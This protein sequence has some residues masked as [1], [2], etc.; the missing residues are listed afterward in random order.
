[1]SS[2]A[3]PAGIRAML[4]QMAELLLRY[5]DP[6]QRLAA[7][8]VLAAP[9][10]FLA[11]AP[12]LPTVAEWLRFIGEDTSAEALRESYQRQGWLNRPESGCKSPS[13]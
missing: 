1:M 11:E 7:A 2:Y 3:P 8:S 4:Y 5:P 10:E 9:N 6:E 12:D 13:N